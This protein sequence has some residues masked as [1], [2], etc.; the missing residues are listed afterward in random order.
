M[1]TILYS[2]AERDMDVCPRFTV[3]FYEGTGVEFDSPLP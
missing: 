3:L 1:C 2:V